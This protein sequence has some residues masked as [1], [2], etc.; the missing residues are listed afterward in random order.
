[1]PTRTSPPRKNVA[2]R[3]AATLR[4]AIVKGR[5]QPGD[6]LPSERELAERYAV[7][8]SSIRE[9]MKRLEAW[10]LVTIRHGGATRVTEFLLN[11]GLAVLPELLEAGGELGASVLGD[12]HE[13]RGLL[14]GWSAEQAARRADPSSVARLDELARRLSEPRLKPADAQTLDYDFF[15]QLVAVTGNQLLAL[16]ARVV[17]DIYFRAPERFLPLYRPDVF[18]PAHHR[19]AVAAIKARDAKAAGDSMRA[20]A[21]TALA[22]LRKETA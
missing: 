1:M 6:P 12:L 20:H 18:E 8:R 10:G 4:S 11:A 19:R 2:E 21:A 3:I 22:L 17:R 9:A 16:F 15:E 13:L 5:F 7:N 14:L